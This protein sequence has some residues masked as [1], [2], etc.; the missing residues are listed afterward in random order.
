MKKN[1]VALIITIIIHIFFLNFEYYF[2]IPYGL[3]MI[4][5]LQDYEELFYIGFPIFTGFLMFVVTRKMIMVF[6][7]KDHN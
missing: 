1:I 3:S 7:D 4:L 5:E 2:F 6:N